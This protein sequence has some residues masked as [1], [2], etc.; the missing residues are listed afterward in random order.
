VTACPSCGG[1]LQQLEALVG[2]RMIPAS[3]VRGKREV[4]V[5]LQPQV[6]VACTECEW[7]EGVA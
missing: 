1:V 5:Q 3:Y 2:V 4:Y 6:V 7:A